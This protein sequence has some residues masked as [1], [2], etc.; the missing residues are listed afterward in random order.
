MRLMVSILCTFLLLA[1]CQKAPNDYNMQTIDLEEDYGNLGFA[2]SRMSSGDTLTWVCYGNSITYGGQ[3]KYPTELQKDLRELYNNEHIYLINAGQPG[4]TA[5]MAEQA[6]DSLVLGYR[7]DM[8]SIVFGINDMYQG[9]PTEDYRQSLHNM[10]DTLQAAGIRVLIMSPTPL[11]NAD[12]SRLIGYC[13]SAQM[14]ADSEQV[15]FF[16]LH[17]AMVN[18]FNRTN[19]VTTVLMPD[20]VHFNNDGYRMIA[21]EIFL[22]WQKMP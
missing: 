1:G 11:A 4:W 15:A 2:E 6:L 18:K 17:K 3:V 7:P 16:H 19:A 20:N 13:S 10:I 12:N 5:P 22:W 9:V 8:V 21:D 14:V